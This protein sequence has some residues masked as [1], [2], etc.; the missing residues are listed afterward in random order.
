MITRSLAGAVPTFKEMQE[1]LT[2]KDLTMFGFLGY[3]C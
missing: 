2:T 3:R 1:N